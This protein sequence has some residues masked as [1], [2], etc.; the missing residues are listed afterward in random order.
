MTGRTDGLEQE[1]NEGE[2]G[3]SQRDGRKVEWDGDGSCE[4]IYICIF[5]R[6][7][8]RSYMGRRRSCAAMLPA[9]LGQ[10]SMKKGMK[11]VKKNEKELE[12]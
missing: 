10:K 6:I 9:C 11:K 3:R 8:M 1:E 5:R 2:L 12:K 7:C 4:D